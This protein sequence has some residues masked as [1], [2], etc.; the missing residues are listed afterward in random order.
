MKTAVSLLLAFAL[1]LARS[2]A[3]TP[4]AARPLVFARLT[5]ARDTTG[6][7]YAENEARRVAE[8]DWYAWGGR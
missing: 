4:P 7:G 6:T 1:S 2:C 3:P 5:L 8:F